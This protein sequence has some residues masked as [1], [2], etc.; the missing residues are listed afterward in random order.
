MMG[1]VIAYVSTV[2]LVYVLV[3]VVENKFLQKKNLRFA[4]SFFSSF[5]FSCVRPPACQPALL[6]LTFIR[7][8]TGSTAR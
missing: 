5:L 6:S 8:H 7:R 2:G 4:P 1:K 3:L